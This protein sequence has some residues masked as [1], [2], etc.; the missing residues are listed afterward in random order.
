MK[1]LRGI[2][3][4]NDVPVIKVG[5]FAVFA[6]VATFLA[7]KA[8]FWESAEV[9][10]PLP[11]PIVQ[12]I[13]QVKPDITLGFAGDIMLAR[14]VKTKVETN[15]NGDFSQLFVKL[16]MIKNF[17]IFFANLEGPVSDKGAD[18]RNLYSFRFDPKVLPILTNAGI[19]IVSFANNHIGDWGRA[20]FDD[21]LTRLKENNLAFT[22]A[23]A[24]LA[25]ATTPT[26]LTVRDAKI[27][28]LGA[29]D[30]GP[31][32]LAATETTSGILLAADPDFPSYIKNAR[33][34]CD[35][36]IV[37]VHWGVEYNPHTKRQAEFA[38]TWIDAGADM[39]IGH[40]PH[41]A[42]DE[43]VYN[44]K[45]IIYSLGNFIFDQYFSKETMQG[46]MIGVTLDGETKRLKKYDVYTIS[47]SKN[48]Q[49]QTPVLEYTKELP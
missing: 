12:E 28:F 49:P 33:A 7:A 27:C 17:D 15:F 6:I 24:S 35:T 30:V 21:S 2:I 8:Y 19:D 45:F 47:L 14:G 29:S 34:S 16:E 40:H 25:E 22:G 18:R 3:P 48:F 20:A 4:P 44:G 32:N 42:Q 11:N 9:N 23:G 26:I 1:K 10:T 36:L 43:E 13:K 5:F 46:K 39:I 31:D 37:S 38:H 41:V